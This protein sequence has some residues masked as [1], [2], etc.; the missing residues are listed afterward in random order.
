MA[1]KYYEIPEKRQV[2]AVMSGTEMD[3]Y[4]KI[5][6]MM[7][8]AGY[9]FSPMSVKEFGSYLMPDD[10][11]VVVTCDE[12]DEYNAEEGKKIAKQRLLSHYYKSLDKRVDKFKH[13]VAQFVVN[14]GCEKV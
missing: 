2:I 8:K 1:I 7:H 14:M 6:K 9:H 12:R 13:S 4:N 3:A 5:R 11:K 10:F